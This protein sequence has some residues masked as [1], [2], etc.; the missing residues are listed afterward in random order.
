M[1]KIISFANHK[2]GVGK[3]TTTA[4]IGTI[5]ALKGKRVLLLDLDA[6]SNLTRYFIN[7]LEFDGME[8]SIYDSFTGGK[9][10]PIR[11][12]RENLDLVPSTLELATLERQLTTRISSETILKKLLRPVS[13]RYDY[14]LL[15]CPPSLGTIVINALVASTDL[16][17]VTTAETMAFK[18]L[19][20][21][22]D[23]VATIQEELN[24]GLKITGLVLTMW[25]NSNLYKK[26]AE[27]L[28]EDYKGIIFKTRIRK[29][30]SVPESQATTLGLLEYAPEATA[31]KDYLALAEEILEREQQDNKQQ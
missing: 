11:N 7:D 22:E 4:T 2:G 27:T 23:L 16:Y 28:E 14:I 25:S 15:D 5:L 21:I 18:G 30:V 19:Y 1:T 31:T 6:Q 9:D 3:S 17:I 20:I 8:L 26:V 13:S 10:L 12:I 29:T 24:P